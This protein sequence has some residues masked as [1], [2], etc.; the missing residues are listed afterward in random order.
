MS[1]CAAWSELRQKEIQHVALQPRF[2]ARRPA[3]SPFAG[4]RRGP[5]VAPSRGRGETRRI[6]FFAPPFLFFF[7]SLRLLYLS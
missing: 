5:D 7:L 4:G 6:S 3:G 1:L 2:G